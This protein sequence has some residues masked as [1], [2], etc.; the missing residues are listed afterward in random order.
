MNDQKVGEIFETRDYSIFIT[1]DWNREVTTKRAHKIRDSIKRNGYV[2]NPICVNE[3]FEVIDGQG[4]LEALK[5]L[6]MPVHYY[7]EVGAGRSECIA[8]NS[9]NTLWSVRDY[10]TSYANAGNDNYSRL[11]SLINEFSIFGMATIYFAATGASALQNEVIKKGN[12]KCTPEDYNEARN[13]LM[14]MQQFIHGVQKL[15]GK[16]SAVYQAIYFALGCEGVDAD[17]LR[18]RLELKYSIAP[19]IANLKQAL[20]A[21]TDIYNKNARDRIYLSEMYDKFMRG[22]YTWYENKWGNSN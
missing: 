17:K 19:A 6:G 15:K 12:M 2:L 7:F 21:L 14:F 10:I 1:M 13:R 8:L 3:H 9:Y 4:R 22:K 11:N 20:D 18:E 16:Q 5:L